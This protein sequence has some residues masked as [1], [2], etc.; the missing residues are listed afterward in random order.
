MLLT[1]TMVYAYRC[2]IAV[3]VSPSICTKDASTNERYPGGIGDSA[4][5]RAEDSCRLSPV[6]LRGFEPLTP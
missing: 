2:C 3:T 6:E 4:R 5:N 1:Y